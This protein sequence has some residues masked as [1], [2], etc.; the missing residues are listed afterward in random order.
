MVHILLIHSKWETFSFGVNLMMSALFIATTGMKVH[1][2]GLGVVGNNLSNVNT[3]AY[4]QEDWLFEDLMYKELSLGTSD[5]TVSN[6]SGM[7]AMLCSVRTLHTQGSFEMTGNYTDLALSGTGFFKVQAENGEEFLTRAGDFIFDKDGYLDDPTGAALLA[8]PIDENGVEG[9]LQ[10]LKLDVVNNAPVSS[11]MPTTSIEGKFN[12]GF[13]T[14]AVQ[15]F[16][17]VTIP[18]PNDPTKTLTVQQETDPYFSLLKSY[19]ATQDSPLADDVPY[20]QPMTI[21]DNQGNKQNITLHFDTATDSNGQ[22]TIE[23]IATIP[24]E[25]DASGT[26][27]PEK[28]GV[29]MAGTLSFNS[30]GQLISMSAFSPTPGADASDLSNWTT[31]ALDENGSPILNLNLTGSGAQQVS[32]NFGAQAPN[33]WNNA[34]TNAAAIGTSFR[35]LPTIGVPQD[36]EAYASTSYPSSGSSLAD[37]RQDGAPQGDLQQIYFKEDGTVVGN[38]SNGKSEDLYRIPIYRVT[39]QDG[40][41]NDGN[42]HYIVT[43]ACG[44]VEEGIAGTENYATVSSSVIETSNVSYEQEMTEMIML[45]RGFQSNSK[46]VITADEMLQK[47]VEMKR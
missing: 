22:K 20:S 45:Q 39:S 15:A 17:T 34:P 2:T 40:L 36:L 35:A 7:G 4:K 5:S 10:P 25:Q 16:E 21:Y 44:A 46:A 47:A 19:D 30:A 28:A 23:F 6:A 24:P 38:F 11:F 14:N 42:N 12:L 3:I 43:D 27:P 13:D 29:L 32:L 37:F 33:G 18:D 31:S 8:Y 9:T 41:Y 1:D 26:T